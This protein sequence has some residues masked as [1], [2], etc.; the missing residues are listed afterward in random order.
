MEHFVFI[1]IIGSFC[2]KQSADDIQLIAVSQTAW[3]SG[4]VSLSPVALGVA[5][6]VRPRLEARLRFV[7]TIAHKIAAVHPRF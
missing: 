4:R 5:I 7:L 6:R 3:A 1:Q 2:K